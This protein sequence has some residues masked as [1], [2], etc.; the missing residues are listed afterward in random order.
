MKNVLWAIFICILAAGLYWLYKQF[1]YAF[2]R[3]D[4]YLNALQIIFFLAVLGLA[5]ARSDIASVTLLKWAAGWM[6][7]MVVGLIGYTY[8]WEL[9]E[10]AFR[11]FGQLLP[12]VGH[13]NAD[14]SVTFQAGE[15]GHFMIGAKVNGKVVQFLLDTGASKITLS[16]QDARHVGIDV[17]NLRYNVRVDTANGSSLVA[18]VL[19]NSLQVGDIEIKDI[20]AHVAQNGLFG[21]LLGTNFLNRLSKYEVGK[22]SITLWQ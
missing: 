14:R 12:S 1:P 3:K 6:V 16:Q 4:S 13:I 10:H 15:N 19:L 5:L 18:Y 17:D 2:T 7:I 8:R 22:G 20:D 21:S 9:K 11:V